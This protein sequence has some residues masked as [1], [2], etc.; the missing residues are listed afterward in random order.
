MDE[1]IMG[2]IFYKNTTAIICLLITMF[3][4]SGSSF[5][6]MREAELFE[7]AY[8]YYLAF[9]P[10]KAIETFDLFLQQFPDSSALDSILFWRAK[11]HMQMKRVEE[12]AKGFRKLREV[13]PESSYAIFAEKELET[14]KKLL[15]K[16]DKSESLREMTSKISD[17]KMPAYEDRIK[18]LE[19]EMLDLE[20]QLSD[21]EKKRQL[22]EKGLSKAL[23]DKNALESQIDELKRSRDDLAQK[24]SLA[25]KGDKERAGLAEEKKTLEAGLKERDEKIR[26]LTDEL[27][28]SDEKIA[29]VTRELLGKMQQSQKDWE[30]LDLH[31]KELKAGNIALDQ[32]VKEKD[33][34]LAD[35]MQS[36]SALQN[37][38]AASE[39]SKQREKENLNQSIAQLSAEKVFIEEQ[40]ALEKKRAD[41]LAAQAGDVNKWREEAAYT[42]TELDKLQKEKIGLLKEIKVLG[43]KLSET[44]EKV[45]TLAVTRDKDTEK[46]RNA[47][48]AKS[49]ALEK[50]FTESE[51]RVRQFIEERQKIDINV[52][53]QEQKLAK[54]VDSLAI[55]EKR[56]RELDKE[57]ES[58]IL[59]LNDKTARSAQEK[60]ALEEELRKERIRTSEISGRNSEKEAA[61]LKEI[62]SLEKLKQD[63][64]TRDREKREM[65]EQITEAHKSREELAGRISQADK[66][67]KDNKRLLEEKRKLELRVREA[68][69]KITAMS[70]KAEGD[71]NRE[72]EAISEK[73]KEA[74]KRIKDSDVALKKSQEERQAAEVR[75][76]E[77]Q[78]VIT[79]SQE[80]IALL[81]KTLK[82]SELEKEKKTEDLNERIRLTEAEKKGIGEELAREKKK[83]A[84]LSGK[85]TEKETALLNDVKTLERARQDLEARL[86]TEKIQRESDLRKFEAERADLQ[87]SA[88]QRESLALEDR[89]R[90][91][92]QAQEKEGQI[93]KARETISLLEK[94]LKDS[95]QEKTATLQTLNDKLRKDSDEKKALEDELK[96]EKKAVATQSGQGVEKEAALQKEIK[97]LEKARAELLQ[98]IG[99]ERIRHASET[100]KIRAELDDQ[101]KKLRV[102]DGLTS[103]RNALMAELEEAK[104]SRDGF[105]NKS[106]TVEKSAK[107][108]LALREEIKAISEKLK[109][110]D[111]RIKDSD[112]ALKKSHEERQAAEV[113]MQEQQ[114]MIT[115]SGE[116]IALLEKTLKASEQEKEKKAQDL[117]ERIRLTEAEK[118]GMG[119]ELARERKKAAELTGKGT[120]KETALL[121]DVKTLEK[122]RQDLEARLAEKQSI[123]QAGVIRIQNELAEAKRMNDLYVKKNAEI[124][125]NFE[126]LQ[127]QMREYEKPFLRIGKEWYSLSAVLRDGML[128]R[129]VTE[130]IQAKN[131]LWRTGNI[132]DDFMA[133]QI[134]ARKAQAETLSAD[135]SVKESLM[136][137]YALTA[138]E[139][140]YLDKYLAIDRL[141]KMKL[142]VPAIT[143]KDAREY[144]D[145]HREQYLHGRENR[146]RVLSLKYGKAD[147]LEKSLIAVEMQQEAQEGKPFDAIARRHSAVAAMKEMSLSRLPDWARVNIESLR[148]GEI[149][150]I[151]SADNEFMI[152]QA[153]PSKPAYRS[154]EEVRKEIVKKLSAEQLGRKQSL[155][156]WLSTLKKDAEFLR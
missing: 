105:M 50:K 14:L 107:D 34:T 71:K 78:A 8:E 21:A 5:A 100:Q 20:K 95:E 77:Q 140:S 79:K 12:A 23:D 74:D 41:D 19:K 10:E 39:A 59:A 115:K 134:L 38:V 24:T 127:F 113:R 66:T 33:R 151:I 25:E 40:A 58:S 63:L 86:A 116:S 43:V 75:M 138:A 101:Q 141:V 135:S 83:A 55:L 6:D 68:D 132:I 85:G 146:I 150:N 11:S 87:T 147:E 81:E 110:A 98:S 32:A 48:L 125:H 54:A 130:K 9:N 37:K 72:I 44:E 111:K 137:Q 31:I 131:A 154:F 148:E 118:K 104:R 80:S 4:S 70:S 69:E 153:I 7:K 36:L 145:K 26:N 82:A 117:N 97:S 46:E 133:E 16:A 3:C 30:K 108:T 51:A 61:L 17:T 42:A 121:H 64:E 93:T 49:Q 56:A 139:G 65:A 106:A 142:A 22:T 52:R 53:E 120:E 89:Q 149:S 76:Q 1:E 124:E 73:L 91:E 62:K 96:K 99:E 29:F 122:A 129:S 47:L 152:I 88:K 128:A 144:Y 112:V 27:N 90:V 109:E 45:R 103:E 155:E 126:S 57:K 15:Q 84:E 136:K 102:I 156:D 143:E 114:A 119:E 67:E 123:D 2:K 13:F 92:R 18:K 94:R 60:A 28:R 35:A